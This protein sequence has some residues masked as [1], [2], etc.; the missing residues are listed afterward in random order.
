MKKRKNLSQ[1]VRFEV[2]KRDCFTCQYCGQKAPDVV[3]QCDHINP[4]SKGGTNELLN[5]ITSCVD[6]N[7]GKSDRLLD[8][9]TILDKQRNQLEALQ[10]R[11]E[12]I[13]LLLRWKESFDNFE[14]EKLNILIHYIQ[15]KIKPHTLTYGDVNVIERL[16]RRFSIEELMNATDDSASTYLKQDNFGQYTPNSIEQFINK[17]GPIAAVRR[18]PPIDQ[19]VIQIKGA[20]RYFLVYSSPKKMKELL[21]KYVQ[22]M[23]KKGWTEQQILAEL[24]GPVLKMTK[25]IRGWAKWIEQIKEWTRSV[26]TTKQPPIVS[27]QPSF[28]V[29]SPSYTLN[30][31]RKMAA[32]YKLEIL[33]RINVILFL[34]KIFKG[35]DRNAFLFKLEKNIQVFLD[36]QSLD[37]KP[38][39]ERFFADFSANQGFY[40]LFVNRERN[41]LNK[42]TLEISKKQIASLLI[43]LFESLHVSTIGFEGKEAENMLLLFKKS[44]NNLAKNIFLADGNKGLQNGEDYN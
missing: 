9:N 39:E 17:I 21:D 34:G 13:E 33:A 25:E 4:V 35:F 3:L 5:L 42:M 27:I 10:E 2:F 1:K 15:H 37:D 30:E 12:Q 11:K 44:Y 20:G 26:G 36:N 18:M 19:M 41:I 14:Q 23:K 22:Q 6:C 38:E 7:N 32:D 16:L 28:E 29:S 40:L 31:L 43:D 24:E 8:D